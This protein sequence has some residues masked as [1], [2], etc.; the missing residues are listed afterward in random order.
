MTEGY[1]VRID[2]G[3]SF[4]VHDHE[5]DIRKAEFAKK[6]GIPDHVYKQFPKYQ[7]VADREAF[8]RWLLSQV[9]IARIRG[10]GVWSGIQW[11]RGS[12][13]RAL[14]AI[15]KWGRKI[16]GPCLFLRMLNLTTHKQYDSYWLP[17]DE[18]MKAG[19][20]IKSMEVTK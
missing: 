10:Y 13:L 16:C 11:G 3:R 2:T 5:L 8:I 7:P 1:F 4:R 18:I 14:K 12:D 6:L 17:F 9:P 20:T 15:H 19:E